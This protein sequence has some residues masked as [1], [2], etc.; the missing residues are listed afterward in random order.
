MVPLKDIYVDSDPHDE[1][2]VTALADSICHIGLQ[3]PICVIKNDLPEHDTPY[4]IV[5]GRQ[6][7]QAYQSLGREYIPCHML[8]YDEEEFADEKKQLAQYEENLLRKHLTLIETCT[9]IGKAKEAYLTMYPETGQGKASPKN[10]GTGRFPYTRVASQRLG[11]SKSTIEKYVQIYE[12]LIAPN[13]L[14]ALHAVEHPILDRVEDLSALAKSQDDIPALVEIL[15]QDSDTTGGTFCSLQDAQQQLKRHKEAALCRQNR[16][17]DTAAQA[18]TDAA[19]PGVLP[20][21]APARSAEGMP[22]PERHTSPPAQALAAAA[23]AMDL[24]DLIAH[25]AAMI[26]QYLTERHVFTMCDVRIRKQSNT[27]GRHRLLITIQE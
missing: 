21:H 24:Q 8:T 4:R 19:A 13:R 12:E 9:L 22:R 3:N 7:Y 26:D 23:T 25:L 17:T 1:D 6:R 2:L 5:S 14:E 11:K 18:H 27:R 10:P 20:D 16:S 15:C